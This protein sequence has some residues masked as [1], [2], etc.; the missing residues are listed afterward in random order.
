MRARADTGYRL[1]IFFEFMRGAQ[2][3]GLWALPLITEEP[4]S[5]G[6]RRFDCLLAA[7]ADLIA[8]TLGEPCPAWAGARERFLPDPWW[9]S[10]LSSG[11]LFA[12]AHSPN[13]FRRRRIYIDGRDLTSDGRPWPPY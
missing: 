2:E 10:D 7:A 11:Q 8:S 13:A 4:R 5:T 12:L 6:D 9:V 1:C 3:C